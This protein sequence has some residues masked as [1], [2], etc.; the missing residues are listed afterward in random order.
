MFPKRPAS[1]STLS[2]VTLGRLVPPEK[3]LTRYYRYQGSLT[4][5]DC[6]QA[7]VWTL[8]ET[9]IQLSRKQVLILCVLEACSWFMK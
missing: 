8:F 7:V 6:N 9:P 1:N 5:P 3:N 4:T 2:G